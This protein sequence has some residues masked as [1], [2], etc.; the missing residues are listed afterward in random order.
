MLNVV[1]PILFITT[2][3]CIILFTKILQKYTYVQKTIYKRNAFIHVHFQQDN[4]QYLK[5]LLIMN[6]SKS[7]V[8]FSYNHITLTT[9]ETKD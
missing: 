3:L 9:L 1:C 7:S 6:T 8:P 4:F 2:L 5:R